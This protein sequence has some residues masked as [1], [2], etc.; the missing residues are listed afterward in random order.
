MEENETKIKPPTNP[1]TAKINLAI[2]GFYFDWFVKK[3]LPAF[4]PQITS[5]YR[6]PAKNASVDGAEN[7]AHL[8]GLAYDFILKYPNGEPVPKAQAKAVFDT[9]VAPN[10]NGF[11]LWEETPAGVWHIH[12]NL[13]RQITEY[14]GI[15]ALAGMGVIGYQIFKSIGGSKHE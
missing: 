13:S 3:Y 6:D 9:Y 15:M 8:H 14:A 2:L 1:L 4:I 5:G 11:A 12:V 10:W 7:S